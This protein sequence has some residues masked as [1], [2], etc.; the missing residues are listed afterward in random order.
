MRIILAHV[1]LSFEETFMYPI[2]GLSCPDY[3]MNITAILS[4]QDVPLNSTR[5]TLC[6]SSLESKD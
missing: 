4:G 6:P 3:I 5:G 2:I 1:M